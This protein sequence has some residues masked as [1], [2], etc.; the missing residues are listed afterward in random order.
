[1][2][3]TTNRA[4]TGPSTAGFLAPI[5]T[6]V[7]HAPL[8]TYVIRRLL[9]GVATLI[10]ASL[11]VF[12]AVQVL[13][14]NAAE[15]ALGIH[16]DPEQVRQLTETLHL[17]QPVLAR[18]WTFATGFIH[19]DFGIS[20][21]AAANGSTTPVWGL[22]EQPLLNSLTL[23]CIALLIII[24]LA[25]ALGSLA[26]YREGSVLDHIVSTMSVIFTSVPEFL[27]GT[28]L[29]TIFFDLLDIL[30]PVSDFPSTEWAGAHLAEIVLPCLTLVL[31]CVGVTVRLVRAET[32]D[33]LKR[34]YVLVPRINRL[35]RK[36]IFTAYV[37]RN[38][39]APSVQ[40]LGMTAQYLI[41]GIVVVETVFAFPGIGALLVNAI[42]TRDVQLIAVVTTIL[43]GAYI[44]VNIVTDII[45]LLLSPTL[46]TSTR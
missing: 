17:D 10:I 28:I 24:P 32:V 4:S 42:Q 3:T 5:R 25:F 8:V 1:M 37:L 6:A 26:A 21:S 31:V 29:I 18:Y 15:V 40:A 46:R 34:N 22:I 20:T 16:A 35:Q 38:S 23:A 9:A 43:A 14:G 36:R 2:T 12:L 30:P 44:V 27:A 39:L 11:L 19:G 13:P 33:V 45:V 7:N 41:G